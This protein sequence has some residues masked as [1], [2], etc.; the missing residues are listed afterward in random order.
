MPD[1]EFDS[2]FDDDPPKSGTPA[3]GKDH[4]HLD[5]D[6]LSRNPSSSEHTMPSQREQK[7][8]PP[9][10]EQQKR[11]SAD[12]FQ[13]DMDALLI[14]AQ[15]PLIIE[16]MKYLTAKD[17]SAATLQIYAE[18]LKGVEVFIKILERNPN[19]YRNLR[20][21]IQADTDCREIE[22]VAF[23]LYRHKHREDPETDSEILRS[24]EMLRNSL[25]IGYNKALILSLIH[26]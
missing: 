16:G 2:L 20:S 24:Y 25:K 19:S 8:V 3:G 9:H 13:P 7:G 14:S 23:H 5:E 21:A 17:F 1:D 11:R 15:S 18:A 4:R 10:G 12:D 26:I 22:S 6:H